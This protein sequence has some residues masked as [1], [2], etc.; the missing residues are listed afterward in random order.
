M[1]R[2]CQRKVTDYRILLQDTGE[3]LLRQSWPPTAEGLKE[4]TVRDFRALPVDVYYYCINAACGIYHPSK[5]YHQMGDNIDMFQETGTWKIVESIQRMT[6]AGLDPLAIIIEGCH[7]AGKDVSL[8]VRMNDLHDR[9]YDRTL[10]EPARPPKGYREPGWYYMSQFKKDHPEYLQGN[11]DKPGSEGDR[12]YWQA[13]ALNYAL[14]PVRQKIYGLIEETV[15]V[16]NTDAITL[17]F[18][19]APFFFADCEAYGQRHLMTDFVKR[20]RTCVKEAGEHRGRPI[21]MMARVPDT[22]E[23]GLRIGLDIEAWLK[24]GLLDAVII[25][26]GYCPFETPWDEITCLGKKAG[27]PAIACFSFGPLTGM[28]DLYTHDKQKLFEQKLRAAALRAYEQGIQGFQFWNF[29]YMMEYY[30][31]IQN[32]PG[33]GRGYEFTKELRDIHVLKNYTKTYELSRSLQGLIAAVYGNAS[34][35][36]QVPASVAVSSDGLGH[37]FTFDV[38]DDLESVERQ[39]KVTLWLQVIDLGVE[40]EL[41]VL[42]NGRKVDFNLEGYRM[43]TY[44]L[45]EVSIPLNKDDVKKGENRLTLRLLKRP[46]NLDQFI[47]LNW[48]LLTIEPVAR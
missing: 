22:I 6:K 29:F 46:V 12:K 25:S 9:L 17:D 34:W 21:I 13:I 37:T 35:C 39:V 24:D 45:G 48:G 10:R 36:G 38:C 47:T 8:G 1:V 3:P 31:L 20:V 44:N 19:R 18:L 40:D 14:A 43:T 33:R 11:P 2:N 16:Y 27:I 30:R 42:W 5:V 7:E 32:E 41:E 4:A 26:G 28:P 23:M 15:N